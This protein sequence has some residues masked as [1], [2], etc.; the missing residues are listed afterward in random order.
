MYE[1]E[2]TLCSSQWGLYQFGKVNVFNSKIFQGFLCFSEPVEAC[3]P[4]PVHLTPGEGDPETE[5]QPVPHHCCR[6]GFHSIFFLSSNSM[7]SPHFL[8]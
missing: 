2:C 7:D 6:K 4:E 5:A 3:S 8:V 1:K